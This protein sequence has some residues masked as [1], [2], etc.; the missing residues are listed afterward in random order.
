[1]ETLVEDKKFTLEIESVCLDQR[2]LEIRQIL[3]ASEFKEE[4]N[5][6]KNVIFLT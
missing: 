5:L 1:M 6:G 4:T 2:L 3:T